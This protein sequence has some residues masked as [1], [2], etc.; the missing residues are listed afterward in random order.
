MVE[1]LLK[2]TEQESVVEDLVT[3]FDPEQLPCALLAQFWYTWLAEQ[4]EAT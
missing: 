4:D 2:L 1:L 3:D